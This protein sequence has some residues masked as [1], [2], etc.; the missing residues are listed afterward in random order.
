MNLPMVA[1]R[2]GLTGRDWISHGEALP[3]AIDSGIPLLPALDQGG[4]NLP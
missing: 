3:F 4:S 1:L 2:R